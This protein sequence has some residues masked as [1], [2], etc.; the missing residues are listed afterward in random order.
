MPSVITLA[1]RS[2]RDQRGNCDPILATM[3]L[4]CSLQL[5]VFVF[6]PFTRTPNRSVDARIQVITPYLLALNFRSTWNHRGNCGPMLATVHL[7][8]HAVRLADYR[9][10]PRE[11]QHALYGTKSGPANIVSLIVD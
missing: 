3:H 1:F 8:Y 7:H 11:K 4:Y 5:E 2:T 6:C 10:F 9:R